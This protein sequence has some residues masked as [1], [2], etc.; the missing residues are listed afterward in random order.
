MAS[1]RHEKNSLS[2]RLTE[3]VVFVRGS[4]RESRH[5]GDTTLPAVVRG[6]LTL[7]LAKPIKISSI[8][9]ELEGKAT[10]TW[11]EGAGPSRI[12]VTEQ[13]KVHSISTVVFKAGPASQVQRATSARPR[14]QTPD[15]YNEPRGQR[16]PARSRLGR[17]SQGQVAASY[18]RSASLDPRQLSSQR[19]R[20]HVSSDDLQA[21]RDGVSQQSHLDPAPPYTPPSGQLSFI[22]ID[23]YPSTG[24]PEPGSSRFAGRLEQRS[25]PVLLTGRLTPEVPYGSPHSSLHSIRDVALSRTSSIEEVPEDDE[26]LDMSRLHSA[27]VAYYGL[28]RITTG[29]SGRSSEQDHRGRSRSRFSFGKVAHVFDAMKERVR[30]QSPRAGSRPRADEPEERGRSMNKGK[31]KAQISAHG[32]RDSFPTVGVAEPTEA[33]GVNGQSGDGWT[34]F[35]RGTYTYPIFFTIPNKSSPTMKADHGSVIWKVKAEVK[36]PGAFKSKMSA[37]REVIVVC[38]PADDDTEETE[39][40][41]IERQWDSQLQYHIQIPKRSFPVGGKIPIQLTIMPLAKIKVHRIIVYLDERTEYYTQAKTHARSDPIQRATLLTVKQSS[42]DERHSEPILPLISDE[43]RAF[44]KSPLHRFLGPDDDESEMVSSYMGPGP[45]S[46]R[47]HLRLPES[48]GILHPSNRAKGS[49]IMVD[50]SLKIILR[51]EKED[52]TAEQIAGKKKLY[53]IV[54]HTP[55]QILS[56]RC[57]PEWTSLPRYDEALEGDSPEDQSTCPCSTR[58]LPKPRTRSHGGEPQPILLNRV[59]SHQ[60]TDSNTS[61]VGSQSRHVHSNAHCLPDGSPSDSLVSRS[62]L[63][64]RLI[65][66]LESETGEAPP[67]YVG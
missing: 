58:H 57:T 20:R 10:T 28:S 59:T 6:L 14:V 24:N 36:R 11:P 7:K 9:L 18:L 56:C 66:G 41:N 22:N 45:W 8:E 32:A 30:S 40:I 62:N 65:S 1:P 31:G 44:R 5:D 17:P 34:I 47:H 29:S 19:V 25:S 42:S 64:E 43:P 27:N 51:V 55:I 50:H 3:P 33:D 35:Q 15:D 37:Y 53:D 26:S 61:S 16:V 67:S 54:I 13:Y 48:C 4:E 52:S 2:I 49:N 63:Y 60:S 38:A 39:G 46:I 12:E 21:Q 23:P